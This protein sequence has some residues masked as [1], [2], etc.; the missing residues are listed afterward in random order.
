MNKTITTKTRK[1]F[2]ENIGVNLHIFELGNTLL[3]ITPKVQVTKCKINW[4]LSN[5]K[6]LCWKQYQKESGGR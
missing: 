5:Q 4:T 3:D 6:L 2:K 1:L